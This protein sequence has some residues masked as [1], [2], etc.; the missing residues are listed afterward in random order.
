M[1]TETVQRKRNGRRLPSDWR[2]RYLKAYSESGL[3]WLSA[4]SAGVSQMTVSRAEGADAD[5]ALE[6]EEARQKY[7]DSL[8]GNMHRLATVKDN[9]VANIVLLKKHRPQDFVERRQ[10]LHLHAH[11]TVSDGEARQL[12]AAMLHQATPATL[13][14][15][16]PAQVPHT[17]VE[18]GES[19]TLSEP[20]LLRENAA[21]NVLAEEGGA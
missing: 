7:A 13:A 12:L 2:A 9:V 10:E 18:V 1:A 21:V 8:E 15:L 4:E 17:L 16:A 14:A 3:R 20:V 19:S 11:A 5:F 6:L